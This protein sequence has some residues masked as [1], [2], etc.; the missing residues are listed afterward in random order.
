MDQ[1]QIIF[2]II[3]WII[4]TSIFLY[5]FRT[6]PKWVTELLQE[7]QAILGRIMGA[8]SSLVR[9]GAE[10]IASD[11]GSAMPDIVYQIIQAMFMKKERCQ[12]KMSEILGG[13]GS[14]LRDIAFSI[15]VNP[16]GRW[17]GQ[18]AVTKYEKETGKEAPEL[19]KWLTDKKGFSIP[20]AWKIVIT[21]AVIIV[22]AILLTWIVSKWIIILKSVGII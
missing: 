15:G 6:P 7:G 5:L 8:N 11:L 20:S 22:V 2:T 18:Y 14:V 1:L 12:Q 16:I 19:L 17:A 10:V 13:I 3:G 4:Q 9:R 21:I